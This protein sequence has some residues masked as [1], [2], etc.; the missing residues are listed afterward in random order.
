MVV[1]LDAKCAVVSIYDDF[2]F[3]E[4]MSA[5]RIGVIGV[6]YFHLLPEKNAT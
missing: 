2:M 4:K 3:K 6:L 5:L 1:W